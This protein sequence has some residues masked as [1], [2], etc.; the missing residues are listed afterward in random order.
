MESNQTLTGTVKR[1]FRNVII[2]GVLSA[3]LGVV[4]LV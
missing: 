1:S 4:A 3:I 2:F